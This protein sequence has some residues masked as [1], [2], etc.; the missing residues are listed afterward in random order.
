MIIVQS[1]RPGVA[2]VLDGRFVGFVKDHCIILY[3]FARYETSVK[4]PA[5]KPITLASLRL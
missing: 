2:P 4:T 1:L 5:C 3:T